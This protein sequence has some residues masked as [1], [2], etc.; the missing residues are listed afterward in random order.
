MA[1]PTPLINVMSMAA[2]KAARPLVRDF[3][4]I[5]RLQA[6]RK[7]PGKFVTEAGRRTEDILRE[8]LR[9]ARPGFGYRSGDAADAG[10]AT[11]RWLV[12]PIDGAL[13]FLHG[14]P[15]FGISIAVERG[16]D[17]VA[18]V[19]Y[20]PVRDELFWAE[21]GEG[22]YLNRHRLRVSDRS[23]MT[24]ALLAT[25]SPPNRRDGK[26]FFDLMF[27]AALDQ[28]AGVRRLGAASLDLCYVA[29]GR[30]EGFWDIGPSLRK[31]AAGAVAVREAGGMVDR[32]GAGVD[33]PAGNPFVAA[34]QQ[35][36]DE[37]RRMLDE[38]LRCANPEATE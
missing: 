29:A 17:P 23:R 26:K 4:E 32:L 6:S 20:E 11:E 1:L 37:L 12:D 19:V 15:H 2:R 22:A 31:V 14:I 13:N 33:A 7:G 18:G 35:L 27:G 38:A 24:D 10:G 28:A 25:G 36:H 9:R 30:F 16:G 21:R 34:N 3:G 5:E 8:E